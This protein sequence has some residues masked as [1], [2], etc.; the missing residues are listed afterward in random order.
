M[1]DYRGINSRQGKIIES[2]KNRDFSTVEDL[3]EICSVSESTIRRDLDYLSSIGFITRFHG[4]AKIN[5]EKNTEIINFT[6]YQSNWA[7]KMRIGKKAAEFVNDGDLIAINTGTTIMAFAQ[8]LNKKKNLSIVL[9]DYEIARLLTS[10]RDF[11]VVITGGKVENEVP[12]LVGEFAVNM[13]STYS[14]DKCFM[15]VRGLNPFDGLMTSRYDQAVTAQAFINNSKKFIVLADSSKFTLQT[16]AVIAPFKKIDVLITD[17][18]LLNY[19]DIYKQITSIP[20][21]SLILV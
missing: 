7:E 10:R 12:G 11:N 6:R 19:P 20:T 3:A 9:T 15:G 4:G 14:F 13:I 17:K 8:N 5:N 16:G 18:G 2:L 21:I 1:R